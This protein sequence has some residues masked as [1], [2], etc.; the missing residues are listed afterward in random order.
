MD[1]DAPLTVEQLHRFGWESRK[2]MR[3]RGPQYDN[4]EA[5]SNSLGFIQWR[6]RHGIT[7]EQVEEVHKGWEGAADAEKPAT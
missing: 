5:L 6:F 1:P 3:A 4:W 2:R 7:D